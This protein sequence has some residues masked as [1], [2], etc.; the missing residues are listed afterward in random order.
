MS[1]NFDTNQNHYFFKNNNSV[2][3]VFVH[4]VG[5][6][7][8][9]WQPQINYFKN[10]TVLTY[11]LLGHGKTTF[12]KKNLFIEDFRVQLNNLLNNL[13]IKELHLI[14][15]SIGS[16]IAIDFASHFGDYL[17]SLTLIAT[18]YKRTKEERQCIIDRLNLAK[19]N[20][21][22]SSMAMNRWFT[23]KYLNSNPNIND[24][25]M[26]ILNKTG[27]DHL[28]FIKAYDFFANYIDDETKVKNIR[29]KTLIITVSDD[30]GST[31]KMS[32][33]LNKDIINSKYSE[34]KNG[35]HLCS[36]EFADDVNNE[37]KKHIINA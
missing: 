35:K 15:F 1:F 9:M 11:D 34:I 4:G 26:N 3:L 20:R 2:P 10:E 29:V 6:N 25:F 31:P 5:L 7:Q 33:E 17:K 28:N 16:L 37:I 8:K 24:E 21:P 27:E 13:N 18:T 19:K 30:P 36:I 32:K 14:G 12:N 23:K 22:I